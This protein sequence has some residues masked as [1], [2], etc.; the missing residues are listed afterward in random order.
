[1]KFL[2]GMF[3]FLSFHLGFAAQPKI[4]DYAQYAN[5]SKWGES[6][7]SLTIVDQHTDPDRYNVQFL[8]DAHKEI[9][10][11]SRPN[12]YSDT[13]LSTC[14]DFPNERIETITV[15]AGTFITCRSDVEFEFEGNVAKA[16][17]WNTDGIPFLRVKEYHQYKDQASGREL[18]TFIKK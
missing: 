7:S 5:F 14:G 6:H 4:G 9:V 10:I 2:A 3:L 17:F 1:M 8:S 13:V 16:T 12:L 15:Q 18:V 11:M